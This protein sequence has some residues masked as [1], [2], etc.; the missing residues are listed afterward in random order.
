MR[1]ES[2]W[3]AA[4]NVLLIFSPTVTMNEKCLVKHSHLGGSQRFFFISSKVQQHHQNAP[5]INEDIFYE[6][7]FLVSCASEILQ[8]SIFFNF[9]LTKLLDLKSLML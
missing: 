2:C 3:G 7:S 5:R 4:V 9:T 8:S 6:E 1:A